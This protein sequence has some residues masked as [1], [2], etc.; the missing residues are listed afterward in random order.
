[1]FLFAKFASIAR[2]DLFN[3][4]KRVGGNDIVFAIDYGAA[5]G[6]SSDGCN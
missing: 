2:V 5:T 1:M 6:F 3:D 4:I